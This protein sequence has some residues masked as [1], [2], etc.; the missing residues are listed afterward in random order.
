MSKDVITLEPEEI[1]MSAVEKMSFNN[2][3]CVVVVEDK[4]LQAY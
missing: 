2:V 4:N 3:S 1:L